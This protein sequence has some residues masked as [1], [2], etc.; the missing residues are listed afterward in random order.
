[1]R[2]STEALAQFREQG[3]RSPWRV[4]ASVSNPQLPALEAAISVERGNTP[5]FASVQA[6]FNLLDQSAAP[7]LQKA[8]EA[9]VFVIIKEALA[10]GRLSSRD[11]GSCALEILSAE[12]AK[13]NTTVDAL[14]LAWV[15]TFPW[16][17]M[18]LSGAST[19]EQ[20]RS[21]ADALRLAPLDATLHTRLAKALGQPVDEYWDARK[22]LK[23]N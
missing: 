13:L 6:T 15:L 20:L 16:V 4:G 12:A 23:W 10:N 3:V 22:A 5:L 7:M 2:C 14:A 19:C 8:A 9:G 17:G 21:N 18:C 11:V 1:M